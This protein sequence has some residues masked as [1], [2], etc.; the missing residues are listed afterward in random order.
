MKIKLSRVYFFLFLFLIGQALKSNIDSL[1]NLLRNDPKN[2]ME[3]YSVL[4]YKYVFLNPDSL[5]RYSDLGL[6]LAKKKG[7]DKYVAHILNCLGTSYYEIGKFDVALENY[8]QSQNLFEQ[9]KDDEGKVMVMGNIGQVYQEQGL[10]E[11]ALKQLE[12]CLEFS[13]QIKYHVGYA[14]TL[15]SIGLLYYRQGNKQKAIDYFQESL[16]EYTSLNDVPRIMEGLNNVAVMYQEL[17]KYQEALKNLET[18]L[19]YSRKMNDQKN[20]AVSFH[21]IALVYKDKKDLNYAI[22]YL[23]SSINISKAIRDFDDQREAYSSLSEIY[24]EKNNLDKA[25]ECFQLSA[26][27]KDSL[28]AQT[29][30]KQ[31][32][33]M[34]TKYETE[35]K[36]KENIRL[37]AKHEQDLAVAAE[38]EK[39]LNVITY[40]ITIGLILVVLFSFVLSQRLKVTRQQKR[41]IE[42]Q[43]HLVDEKQKEILDS[44]HYAQR[45]Q[46]AIL[47]KEEDIQKEFPQSFLYYQPKDIVAGDF[48]FFESTNTHVFY[49]A[50]DC[51]GHGV[52]GA[53]VSVV[54]ANALSRCVLEFDLSD[55]G[56]ILDKTR[57]LVVETFKKSGQ[58]V[59][60]GMDISLLVKEKK[61]GKFTW[62]GANN[63][64][65]KIN[66]NTKGMEEIKGN[67]Q[68]IGLVENPTA[69]TTHEIKTNKG[70]TLFVFTDGM[71]DQFGGPKGKKYKYKR[72]QEKILESQDLNSTQQCTFLK[73]DLIQWMGTN[74]QVDDIL[75][76]GIRV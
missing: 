61:G 52:P 71:P 33:E 29:R 63:P 3:I 62:A 39:K 4:C 5:H 18:F 17:G 54:C 53:L 48:Y 36:E 8:I 35:K 13:K 12:D 10:F 32:I 2:K 76:I 64:V 46:H 40:S 6:A 22:K 72:L 70:D 37:K 73:N 66:F 21:N 44:I 30:A 50:A 20:I 26:A 58:D 28:L 41:I 23:D 67:K 24:K 59:K 56:K 27:A 19:D 51:T 43:K 65:W 69:F 57:E 15:S 31:L 68:P 9:Y 14:G 55:P 75:L 34:S 45:I 49:A 42:K 1:K 11:K 7:Y 25:L 74:E 47:A 16:K 60:D 38:K